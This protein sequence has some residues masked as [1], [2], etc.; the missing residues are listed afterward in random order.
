ME[1]GQLCLFLCFGFGKWVICCIPNFMEFVQF[2]LFDCLSEKNELDQFC[3]FD[4]LSKKNELDQFCLFDC[5][6]LDLSIGFF[7]AMMRPSGMMACADCDHLL[8]Q[9]QH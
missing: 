3:L 7:W 9:M 5:C 4:C 1:L 8:S 2:C 6:I